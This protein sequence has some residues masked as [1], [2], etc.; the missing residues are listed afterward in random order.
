[1]GQRGWQA[2]PIAH[3]VPDGERIIAGEGLD[4]E[5]VRVVRPKEDAAGAIL[6]AVAG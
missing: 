2:E 4:P 6:P 3:K 5:P 1:V